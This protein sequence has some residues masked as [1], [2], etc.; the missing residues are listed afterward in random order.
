MSAMSVVISKRMTPT[1]MAAA[2]TL[3]GDKTV[4][5]LCIGA[6][7]DMLNSDRLRITHLTFVRNAESRK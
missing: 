1:K 5:M 6:C 3:N 7:A 2:R 4:V